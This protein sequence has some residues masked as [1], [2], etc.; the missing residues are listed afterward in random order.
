MV[1]D[2]YTYIF[3]LFRASRNADIVHIHWLEGLYKGSSKYETLIKSLLLP[4]DLLLAQLLGIPIVWTV[5]NI[6]PHDTTYP[7]LYGVL[8]HLFSRVATT[9][10]VHDE[11]TVAEIIS[12]YRL[13]TSVRQKCEVIPHGNYIENYPN[14]VGQGEARSQLEVGS[15]ETVYLFLG[16]IRPYKGVTEL[17]KSFNTLEESNSRLI[18]AG[19][20]ESKEYNEQL[21]QLVAGDDRIDYRPEFVPGEELQLYFNAAD[22]AVFPFRSVLTSGSVLLALSF[23]CPAVVPRIGNVGELPQGTITY[24]PVGESVLEG[25]RKATDEDLL[26]LGDEGRAFAERVDWG[27]I[28]DR[29]VSVY[30]K[31]LS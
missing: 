30:R 14:D 25:L 8:G 16:L 4:I 21:T 3:S 27:S 17:I 6:K 19:K 11:S 28:G 15:D 2:D 7:R 31:S 13:P 29:M 9:I 22:V 12:S 20:P 18:I 26:A 1:G 10:H 23:G 24:D 5:H